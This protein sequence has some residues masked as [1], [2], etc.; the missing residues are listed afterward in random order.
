ML[1]VLDDAL[2]NIREDVERRVQETACTHKDWP[3]RKGCDE[4][5]RRLASVPRI[6]EEEW[7]LMAAAI[8]VL[9]SGTADIAR[10]R[11]RASAGAPRPVVCPLLDTG[12]GTCL[13]YEAR[14][15]A[16]RAYGFYAQRT[17]VLGCERIKAVGDQS[18][19]VV[20]GNYAALEARL[21]SL[22]PTAELPVWLASEMR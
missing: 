13:I 21:R 17:D 3:C 4:C 1:S 5:C 6:S 9:P 16:C 2:F 15:V 11:I 12:A 8:D 10:Q 18:P 19:D 20:W 7:R 22:G 14:P